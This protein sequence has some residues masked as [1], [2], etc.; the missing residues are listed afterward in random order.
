VE[1]ACA[2]GT[3][4]DVKV[5]LFLARTGTPFSAIDTKEW[6]DVMTLCGKSCRSGDT[7]R[8]VILPAVGAQVQTLVRKKLQ[9]APAAAVVIDGW[10][11]RHQ[12]VLGIVLH[13]VTDDWKLRTEV[14][15]LTRVNGPQTA[16]NISAVVTARVHAFLG[17][18]TTIAAAISDNGPNYVNA[19]SKV[20]GGEHWPCVLH[21][22]QLAIHDA[23]NAYTSPAKRILQRVHEIVNMIRDSTTL[24]ATLEEKQRQA[25]QPVRQLV[26][27]NDTRWHSQLSMLERFVEVFDVLQGVLLD[28]DADLLM[29]NGDRAEATAIVSTLSCVRKVS[30]ALESECTVTL[31]LVLHYLHQL[32]N[33]DLVPSSTDIPAT[34]PS[35][36]P[37]AP[38]SNL[39]LTL[40]S[41]A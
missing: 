9:R 7:L 33:V 18:G 12:K 14:V 37:C 19:G 26:L 3:Q 13:R 22:L 29:D 40:C 8:R 27:E 23:L 30:R 2:Q 36:S 1:E 6:R 31:S 39:A 5:L 32:V 38:R 41:T 25:G 24:R 17:E 34:P 35:R 4:Q 28:V 15:G 11:L 20:A 10:D 16:V 21:T